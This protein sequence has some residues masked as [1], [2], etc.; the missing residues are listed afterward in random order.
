MTPSPPIFEIF[1]FKRTLVGRQ[2]VNSIKSIKY[3]LDDAAFIT[4]ARLCN[5]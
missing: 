1:I 3:L 4:S 2:A 5:K